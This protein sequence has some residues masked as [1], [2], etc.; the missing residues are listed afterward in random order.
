MSEFLPAALSSAE[1]WTMIAQTLFFS[2][3][4]HVFLFL[5]P[6]STP[7]GSW[8]FYHAEWVLGYPNGAQP[9]RSQQYSVLVWECFSAGKN[10]SDCGKIM[11]PLINEWQKP[12]EVCTSVLQ[13]NSFILKQLPWALSDSYLGLGL[14]LSKWQSYRPLLELS[15]LEM[16]VKT[17]FT[18]S[19]SLFSIFSRLRVQLILFL[20]FQ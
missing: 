18:W 8:V 16:C 6:L 5:Y 17:N 15:K 1:R 14:L 19:W 9:G 10:K 11:V 12:S 3:G 20:T 4:Q 7:C 13:M 2:P